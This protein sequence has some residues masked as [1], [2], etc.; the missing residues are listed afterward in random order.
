M[1]THIHLESG[2][3]VELDFW[4]GHKELKELDVPEGAYWRSSSALESEITDQ[5]KS[6]LLKG[7][8][9]KSSAVMML[10]ACL[11]T[12]KRTKKSGDAV[13][14]TCHAVHLFKSNGFWWQE[15]EEGN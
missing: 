13:G 7:A 11:F 14:L 3:C 4:D 15:Q 6:L 12:V 9:G 5:I 2:T 10:R 1:I 8:G